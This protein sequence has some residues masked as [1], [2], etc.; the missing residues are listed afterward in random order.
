LR[1]SSDTSVNW[2]A[3]SDTASAVASCFVIAAGAN[4]PNLAYSAA[5]WGDYDNDGYPDLAIMGRMPDNTT[6]LTRIY[7]NNHNGTF[8]DII[9]G[10]PGLYDGAVAWGDYDNDGKLDLAVTGGIG[11]GNQCLTKIY[12]NNGDGT[13]A[14]N[15][16]AVLTGVMRSS[17]AWVITIMTETSIFWSLA[18]LTFQAIV[19]R[20]TGM[21]MALLLISAI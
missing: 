19:Q 20:Y 16:N 8:T 18:I 10:L 13:F 3:W 11:N 12:H 5:A 7:H 4:L 21:I 9:A 6:Y 14:E 1:A 15:T 17:L 2:S